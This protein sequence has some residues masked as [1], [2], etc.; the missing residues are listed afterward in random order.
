MTSREAKFNS[1]GV[2]KAVLSIGVI[3]VGK[4]G[5]LHLKLLK[6]LVL[7]RRDLSIAGVWDI[8]EARLK[9][10]ASQ[11]GVLAFGSLEEAI[12]SCDA[13]II[14]ASA[15]AHYDLGKAFLQRGVHLFIE[16]PLA[17]TI[18]QAEELIA[19]ERRTGAKIQVGHIERFNP[20]LV[21]A[22]RHLG[23]PVFIAAERLSGFS[24]RVSDVSVVLD[25]MIHDI[26]LI[27]S[28]V[29]SEVR[30]VVASGAS[31]FSGD[32]DI[33]NARLE[34]QNGAV[35]SV[36]ASRISRSKLRKMRF[37]CKH[38]N[39]YASLDLSAGKAEIFRIVDAPSARKASLKEAATQKIL[40]L[41]GDIAETLNGKTIEY[42]APEP[43]KLNPLK[44]EQ[45]SFFDAILGGAPIRV[46]SEAGRRAL[47]VAEKITTEIRSSLAR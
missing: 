32:L 35:A 40:N 43:P 18:A 44:E 20:A 39:S 23:E 6:E 2:F 36:T 10:V 37:F 42:L 13:A 30:S 27:L 33:A 38:P 34:F 11:H 41:F 4:L 25:L 46:D 7:E 14:A 19:L 24:R 5:E 45:R 47:E 31:V 21:A 22:E 8:S 3:G 9:A 26:D 29:K 16:K 15:S 12:E 1:S 28:L 17:A